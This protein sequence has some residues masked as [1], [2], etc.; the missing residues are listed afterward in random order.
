MQPPNDLENLPVLHAFAAIIQNVSC[1]E[2]LANLSFALAETGLA[3]VTKFSS[4]ASD[5]S[6][7]PHS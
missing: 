6:T 1:R 2:L 5:L 3:Q 7:G 4:C